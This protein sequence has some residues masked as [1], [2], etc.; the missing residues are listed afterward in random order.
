[1]CQRVGSKS[2]MIKGSATSVK[3]L[4]VQWSGTWRAI[5]SEVKPE[6]L[7][8][9][10]QVTVQLE[11]AVMSLVLTETPRRR[12]RGKEANYC[13]KEMVDLG[14]L[15]YSRRCKKNMT[16]WPRPPYRLPLLHWCNSLS[17][18][19]FQLREKEGPWTQ[20]KDSFVVCYIGS[21][22]NGSLPHY[23]T[24]RLLITR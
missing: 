20:V 9:V 5:H 4:G 13:M 7:T 23:A 24:K 16:C 11:L 3:F 17:P 21:Y 12:L 15:K 1:M 6:S 2:L 19:L 10:H 8:M 18:H 22:R 14:R